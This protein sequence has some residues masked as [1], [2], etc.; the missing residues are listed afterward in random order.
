MKRKLYIS[1]TL[2]LVLILALC[3]CS[4]TSKICGL[5]ENEA[6]GIYMQLRTDNSGTLGISG[7]KPLE[8]SYT[9]SDGKLILAFSEKSVENAEYS[10][11]LDGDKLTLKSDSFELHL[12]RFENK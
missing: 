11:T 4:K 5:W 6:D 10:Y 7:A 12:T 2:L 3:S 9:I 1:I 8:F